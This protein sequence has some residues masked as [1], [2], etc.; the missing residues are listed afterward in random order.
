VQLPANVGALLAIAA[1]KRTAAQNEELKNYYLAQDAEY[2]RLRNTVNEY[3]ALAPQARL[4]GVQDLAWA[5]INSPA[6][7]FNR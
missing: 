4:V 7:L 6:F 5:M 2:Q 1:D 3:L